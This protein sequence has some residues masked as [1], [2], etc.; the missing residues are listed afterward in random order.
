MTGR[1]TMMMRAKTT[2]KE[3]CYRSQSKASGIKRDKGEHT[4]IGKKKTKAP[5]N[6]RRDDGAGFNEICY[7]KKERKEALGRVTEDGSALQIIAISVREPEIKRKDR[8]WSPI[9]HEK[10]SNEGAYNH[11]KIG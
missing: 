10:K 2:K 5:Q 4:A 9:L 11:G 6:K 8:G 1:V 3:T 7:W